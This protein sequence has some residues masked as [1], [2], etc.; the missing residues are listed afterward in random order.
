M[1]FPYINVPDTATGHVTSDS[2]SWTISYPS[3]LVAGDL[4]LMLIGVDDAPA[5]L[6]TDPAGFV[7]AGGV[8]QTGIVGVHG[9]KRKSDGTESGTFTL[10]LDTAQQGAWLVY[11]ISGWEG[12]L[13]TVANGPNGGAVVGDGGDGTG[14]GLDTNPVASALTFTNWG[15][16][17]YT[18]GIVAIGVDA[19]RTVTGYPLADNQYSD[20][21]GGATGAT[22]GVCSGQTT[23]DVF[24]PGAFTISASDDWC[25]CI[26]AIHGGTSGLPIAT[27]PR[28]AHGSGRT[29]W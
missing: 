6:F 21:S 10:T 23:S 22:L 18:L 29:S 25:C 19:S 20:A 4:I 16:G 27:Q 14:T 24:G 1:A 13:G 11:R 7:N 17:E 26:W 2:A 28:P 12:T 3:N 8:N 5:T 15:V 9:W